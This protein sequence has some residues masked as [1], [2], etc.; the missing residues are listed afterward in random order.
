MEAS[1]ALRDIQANKLG[2]S[3]P[4]NKDARPS[5]N[6][7]DTYYGMENIAVKWHPIFSEIPLVRPTLFICQEFFDALPVYQFQYTNKGWREKM[8]D[9]N[10]S[11]K[12]K[13]AFE[14]VLSPF[15][16]L[17]T[18]MLIEEGIN[19]LKRDKSANYVGDSFEVSPESEAF[20]QKIGE[21]INNYGGAGIVIDYGHNHPISN[22]LRAIR[23]HKF[24]SIF[25]NVGSA[26][27]SVNV[28]FSSLAN[29]VKDGNEK[30]KVN[31]LLTQREWLEEMGIDARLTSLLRD[32]DDEED[33]E[34]LTQGFHRLTSDDEM[35]KI[36]KVLTFYN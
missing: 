30:V 12:T 20:M 3:H 25:E 28:D 31:A 9:L 10:R 15:Q 8:V 21:T 16:T 36:Y 14:Y 6:Y 13:E 2:C 32:C 7:S 23:Q 33:A 35:G 27:L 19:P 1:P 5:T 11:K 17:T 18:K 22:S 29:S 24:E 34:T 26:D 4:A